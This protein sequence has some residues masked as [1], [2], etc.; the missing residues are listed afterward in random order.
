VIVTFNL[1]DFPAAALARYHIE[2]QHPDEFIL[3]LFSAAPS[4]VC[5]AVQRQ[6]AGLRNPPKSAEQLLAMLENQGL[7]QTVRQLR[8]Y[9]NVL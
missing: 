7:I 3:S 4:L 6:R 5:G 1:K 8:P 2:A 9:A